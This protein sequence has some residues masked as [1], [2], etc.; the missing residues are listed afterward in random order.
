M[1]SYNII[2]NNVL[3]CFLALEEKASLWLKPEERLIAN[4]PTPTAVFGTHEY[5][6]NGHV[7]FLSVSYFLSMVDDTDT[8]IVDKIRP[9]Y[10]RWDHRAL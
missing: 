6:I 3:K 8:L 5:R 4:H 1:G 2:F 9:T 10:Y 7:S